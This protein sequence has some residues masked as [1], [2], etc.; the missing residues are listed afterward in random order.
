MLFVQ[1]APPPGTVAAIRIGMVMCR[2]MRM[3]II[4]PVAV[5][6]ALRASW[7][8]VDGYSA[9]LNCDHE[10]GPRLILV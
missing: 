4:V 9:G 7:A 6:E 8:P 1:P 2:G 3:P 10:I 5:C